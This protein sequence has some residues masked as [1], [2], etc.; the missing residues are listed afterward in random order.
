MTLKAFFTSLPPPYP[1]NFNLSFI[2]YIKNHPTRPWEGITQFKPTHLQG[3]GGLKRKLSCPIINAKWENL[4]CVPNF[5]S[6]TDTKKWKYKKTWQLRIYVEN[7]HDT[8]VFR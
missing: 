8:A 2:Y 5:R 3:G 7:P 4:M 6:I 1:S